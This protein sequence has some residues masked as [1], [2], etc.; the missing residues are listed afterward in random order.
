MAVPGPKAI[1]WRQWPRFSWFWATALTNRPGR[2]I[3]DIEVEAAGRSGLFSFTRPL[4]DHLGG[5]GIARAVIS[6]NCDAAIRRVFPDIDEK[7]EVFVPRE[8]A[9]RPKPHPDHV[10]QAL[11]PLDVAA[12]DAW[13][14]G[15]HPTDMQAGKAAGCGC[16]GVASGKTSPEDLIRAGADKILSHSG[17]LIG[18]T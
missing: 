12:G 5:I 18:I 7:C 17:Y 11:R 6:R 3:Q 16:V 8:L 15:D 2:V 13:M 9:P 1:C 10:V 4:L 14:V